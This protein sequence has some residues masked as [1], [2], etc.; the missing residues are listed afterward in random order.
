MKA[1]VLVPIVMVDDGL[2]GSPGCSDILVV[3][4]ILVIV[5]VSFFS[6]KFS[7]SFSFS[8]QIILVFVIVLVIVVKKF[9]N[10]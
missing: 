4:L 6:N 8:C 3:N 5:I 2:D 9:I 1:G 7:F 10:E